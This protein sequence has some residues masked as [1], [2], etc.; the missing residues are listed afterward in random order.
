M[1]GITMASLS[2]STVSCTL[3]NWLG[4]SNSSALAKLARNWKVPVVV[5]MVL[6]TV[7]RLPSAS[8]VRPVRSKA[9]AG[10]TAPACVR[11]RIGSRSSSGSEN[12]T[13]I[14]CI[15][16]ISTRPLA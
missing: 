10:K 2:T 6:S 3:T 16:L 11:F 7:A 4:Y 5:L 15:W 14:G 9:D 13:E 8:L 12:S 1:I